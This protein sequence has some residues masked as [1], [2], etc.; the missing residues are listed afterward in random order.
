MQIKMYPIADLIPDSANA[1]KHGERNIEAIMDS[2]REFGQYKPIVIQKSTRRKCERI[3]LIGTTSRIF[4]TG[5][6]RGAAGVHA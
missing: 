1:R 5:S 2:L 6:F 3:T 4:Q